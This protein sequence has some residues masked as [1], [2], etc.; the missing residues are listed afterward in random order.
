MIIYI[1]GFSGS[2][3]GVKARAFREYF[4]NKGDSYIAPSLSYVPDLAIKT[5]EELIESYDGDVKLIGSSLGG[6]YSIYLA[7]KY[8]LKAVLINPSIH[9]YIT[10]KQVLGS[11]PSFYDESSFTW[12]ESH[13]EMLE[14]YETK[15]QNQS[16]FMLLVQKGDELLDYK[17]AVDKLPEAKVLVE[18]GG[19]HGF[20]GIEKH[21][22]GVSVFFSF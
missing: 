21:F 13:I 18:D 20:D 8:N 9:P 16:D 2:G 1:H 12:M 19:S 15:V 17:E 22:E 10:L 11:A 3:E 6:F 5:L 14:K 4:K 7:N